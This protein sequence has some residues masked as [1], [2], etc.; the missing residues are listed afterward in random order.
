MKIVDIVYMGNLNASTGV[1]SILRSYKE[2]KNL[3]LKLGI[4]LNIFSKDSSNANTDESSLGKRIDSPNYFKPTWRSK[5]KK[6]AVNNFL[7]SILLLYRFYIYNAKYSISKYIKLNRIPD[8]FFFQDIFSCYYF[9]KKTKT[10]TKTILVL[11]TNGETFKMLLDYFPKLKD[12]FIHNF[13]LKIESYVLDRIDS[14]GFVSEFSKNEFNKIHKNKYAQKAF[15]VH[16]GISLN[17]SDIKRSVTPKGIVKLVCAASISHRK[18]QDIIVDA[19]SKLD[20]IMKTKIEIVFLGEGPL[21]NS[22]EHKCEKNKINDIIRFEGA[23]SNVDDYL[24]EADAFILCSRDEGLPMCI[25]EA[26]RAG[27]PIIG[28]RVAGI[29]EQIIDGENGYLIEPNVQSLS[30]VLNKLL[31]RDTDFT[32]MGNKSRELFEKSFTLEKMINEYSKHLI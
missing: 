22:L 26:M 21:K 10:K 19:V 32:E 12:S 16:N 4:E 29:P 5:L 30:V 25:I 11:H 9:L 13:L 20:E 23:V 15:F 1:S 7:L 18:G 14:V 27:L 24:R 28:T 6:L 2:N 31:N 17:T 8:V 3:F